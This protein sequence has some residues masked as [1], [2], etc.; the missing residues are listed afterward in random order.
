MENFDKIPGSQKLLVLV[1]LM[2]GIFV[3]FF[4]GIQTGLEEEITAKTE[5]R[6]RL[7]GQRNQLRASAENIEE[8]RAEIAALCERQDTFLEKLPAR[9]EV[10]SLLQSIHQQA[11]LVGLEIQTFD[12]GDDVR[13]PNY[14][15][16]P[17]RMAVR[18]TYDQITDFFYFVGR[19]QR[20]VNARNISMSPN[21][22]AN[23]WR[24]TE[25]EA[26]RALPEFMRNRERPGPPMLDVNCEIS[27][28]YA[29]GATAA[30]GEV[31]AQQ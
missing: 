12:L 20:I 6:N 29:D 27:T 11:R 24:T 10:P 2:V 25:R 13:G 22:R 26:N 1:L 28:Y 9:A 17:V 4:L 14:T 23:P 7:E 18:G 3:A 5:Q 8:I 30:G 16:I 19:Q 21:T 15:R 31:C